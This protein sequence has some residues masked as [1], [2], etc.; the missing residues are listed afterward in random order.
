MNFIF[1]RSNVDSYLH[2]DLLKV[3]FIRCNESGDLESTLQ[4][5][6]IFFLWQ[7]D[8]SHDVCHSPEFITFVKSLARKIYTMI[9]LTFYEFVKT[10]IKVVLYL[11]FV[12]LHLPNISKNLVVLN[13][14]LRLFGDYS[15]QL[16]QKSRMLA[17]S[18]ADETSTPSGKIRTDGTAQ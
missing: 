11:N 18:F 1:R 16:F 7:S 3:K 8:R 6:N 14:I 12:I 15:Q 5:G 13:Y 10:L 4:I 2:F 9:C 17:P